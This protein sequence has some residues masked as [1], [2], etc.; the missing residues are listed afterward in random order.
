MFWWSEGYESG[1]EV[2]FALGLQVGY[3]VFLPFRVALCGLAL[4]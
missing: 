3:C 2:S 1:I 4:G